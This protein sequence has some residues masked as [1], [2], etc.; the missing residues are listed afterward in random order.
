ML[1]QPSFFSIT[2]RVT[3]KSFTRIL[4]QTTVHTWEVELYQDMVF[5]RAEHKKMKAHTPAV[6]KRAERRGGIKRSAMSESEET[7]C[8]AKKRKT[9][10]EGTVH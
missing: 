5:T 7:T 4:W 8:P 2:D 3:H 1:L 9:Y 10:P 6:D